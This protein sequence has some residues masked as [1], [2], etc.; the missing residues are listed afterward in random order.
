MSLDL[1][2]MRHLV[3]PKEKEPALEAS[4][5]ARAKKGVSCLNGLLICSAHHPGRRSH[6]SA[7][8]HYTA[9]TRFHSLP[10]T[11]K[12]V[13]EKL[14]LDVLP[15]LPQSSMTKFLYNLPE[16]SVS[17]WPSQRSLPWWFIL[18]YLLTFLALFNLIFL[19]IFYNICHYLKL[20]FKKISS[21]IYS[22]SST[23]PNMETS[24]QQGPWAIIY[25]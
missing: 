9:V 17:L 1:V 21:Y 14:S 2:P 25:C 13:L 24:S 16:D 8:F 22:L 10:P 11:H 20:C 12:A 19:F 5:L 18:N 4:F 3:L 6:H 7:I 15:R 23:H